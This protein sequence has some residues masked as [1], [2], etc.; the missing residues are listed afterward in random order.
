MGGTAALCP[1]FRRL[2]IQPNLGLNSRRRQTGAG[3]YGI[4][5][6]GNAA[7]A[8]L[9]ASATS[10]GNASLLSGGSR[11]DSGNRQHNRSA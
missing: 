5:I 1:C 3:T 7:T 8:T 6:G 2:F 10:A 9:A 11:S 4:D